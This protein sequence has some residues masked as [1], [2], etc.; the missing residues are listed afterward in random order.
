MIGYITVTVL[1]LNKHSNVI[2]QL[3]LKRRI[4]LSKS[5]LSAYKKAPNRNDNVLILV[6]MQSLTF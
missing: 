6:K 3:E 1:S 5:V 2:N 4:L